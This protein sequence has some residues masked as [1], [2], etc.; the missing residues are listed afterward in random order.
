MTVTIRCC[1]QLAETPAQVWADVERLETHPD[2]MT[3]ALNIEF[4]TTSHRGVGTEFA[5]VTKLGPLRT[6]DILVVTEWEP[7]S[8]MAIE[9]RGSVQGVGRF[10]LRAAADGTEFCWEE[11]LRFPWWMG[12]PVGERIARPFF[13][14]LWRGNLARLRRRFEP[15]SA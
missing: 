15:G 2:W 14:R 8:R 10:L 3:D 11:T 7:A 1:E 6:R 5:C 4:L 9:H 12:G 13:A